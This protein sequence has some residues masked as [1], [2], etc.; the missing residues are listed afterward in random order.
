[1]L[2]KITAVAVTAAIAGLPAV[3]S[4]HAAPSPSVAPQVKIDDRCQYPANVF[5]ITKM[6]FSR[7]RIQYGATATAFINVNTPGN[8]STPTGL[9]IL[10]I[11]GQESSGTLTGSEV[12]LDVPRLKR[13]SYTG[14]G[15]YRSRSC[16]K[17]QNSRSGD[18]PFQ[19]VKARSEAAAVAADVARDEKPRVRVSVSTTTG[20]TPRG[21]VLISISKGGYVNTRAKA[22]K[23]G[24]AVARFPAGRS[25]GQY[26]VSVRYTGSANV[27]RDRT[28]T[29]FRVG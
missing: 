3:S 6:D 18:I 8:S 7:D 15:L 22:L 14:V 20:I 28:S 11:A 12:A 25:A 9:G 16:A 26:D 13:G 4:A 1:M 27:K 5:T 2:R 17:F 19:V 24:V 21:E 29:T 23:G 10:R